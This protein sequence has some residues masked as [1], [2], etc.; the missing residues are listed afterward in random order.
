[1][2]L[3]KC[4]EKTEKYWLLQWFHVI[5][6]EHKTKVANSQVKD[7]I[8]APVQNTAEQLWEEG[9]KDGIGTFTEKKIEKK[10]LFS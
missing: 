8:P 6:E 3:D 1:M 4:I 9:Q 2:F 7:K 10:V 5:R